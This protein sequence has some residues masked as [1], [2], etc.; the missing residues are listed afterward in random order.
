MRK[1]TRL[2]TQKGFTLIECMVAG[3]VMT[4]GILSLASIFAQGLQTSNQAQIQY[5][6]QQKAQEML[7]TIFTA[8]D[9]Q[10]L[11]WNQINNVGVSTGVFEANAQPLLA[12]GPDGL[13][14][15]AD[16]VTANP[17]TIVIGPGPDKIFGTADDV[18]INLN[19]FMT[20]TVAISPASVGGVP[21]QT[22]KTIQVTINWTYEGKSSQYQINCLISNV[23]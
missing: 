16:D 14:G 23:S 10:Q 4:A 7:E 22:L 15:T 13:Y 8:R 17:D 9:T 3:L 21:S 18:I 6:A 2:R 12:A 1:V 19:P 20:R 5:I 11:T